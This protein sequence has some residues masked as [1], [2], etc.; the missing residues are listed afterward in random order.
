MA[1]KKVPFLLRIIMY[2]AIKEKIEEVRTSSSLVFPIFSDIHAD[3]G[4]DA[5]LISLVEALKRLE[6]EIHMDLIV[7]LGDN[8]SML[9]RNTHLSNEQASAVLD[10]VLTKISASIS[11][12]QYVINGNHDGLGTDFFTPE[13]WEPHLNKFCGNAIRKQGKSYYYVD[14][15][16]VRWVFLS[17]PSDSDIHLTEPTPIWAFGE[18]QLEWLRREALDTDLPVVLFSHV[19]FFYSYNKDMA[20]TIPVWTGETE[21]TV[22]VSTVSGRIDDVSEA[23]K[24]IKEK[25][26]A[27]ACFSGHTHKDA[28]FMPFEEIDG[29]KNPLPCYQVVTKN[30]VSFP[31]CDP[32]EAYPLAIDVAV[33]NTKERNIHVFRLGDGKDRR[34][35][36]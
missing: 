30:P 29:V 20:R 3:E 13:F 35:A 1:L 27:V 9:G 33:L 23:V 5:R 19:P 25:G 4:D 22:H 24:I 28:L 8:L 15:K 11:C 34:F 16:Q 18:E 17:V 12:E 2:K 31:W 32:A 10:R 14:K 6:Q 36:Y 7:N 26:N 21:K